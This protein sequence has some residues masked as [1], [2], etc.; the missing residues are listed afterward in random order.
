MQQLFHE[1]GLNIMLVTTKLVLSEV[2]TKVAARPIKKSCSCFSATC[3]C[4]CLLSIPSPAWFQTEQLSRI[5][6]NSNSKLAQMRPILSPNFLY[7]TIISYA[8][9][10]VEWGLCVKFLCGVLY[11]S[12]PRPGAS[13][14]IVP[15]GY[16]MMIFR[17]S[18]I[19]LYIKNTVHITYPHFLLLD[20]TFGKNFHKLV[21]PVYMDLFPFP[22]RSAL[23]SCE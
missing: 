23:V 2:S 13:A 8:P 3:C 21:Y 11:Q 19:S 18:A 17:N 6:L 5:W 9:K 16:L 15:E 14:G 4:R 22:Y 12:L 7:Y 10:K 20:F 1:D